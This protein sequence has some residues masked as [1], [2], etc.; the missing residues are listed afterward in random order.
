MAGQKID[1]YKEFT[2]EGDAYLLEPKALL[3]VVGHIWEDEPDADMST[4]FSELYGN[5]VKHKALSISKVH[6]PYRRYFVKERESIVVKVGLEFET[7]NIASS[8]RAL[9]KLNTLYGEGYI[10]VGVFITSDRKDTTAARIWPTRNRNGSFQ[11]LEQRQYL[12]NVRFPIWEFAFQPDGYDQRAPYLNADRS[13]YTPEDTGRTRRHRGVR[14]R[15]FTRRLKT[16]KRSWK[17][18]GRFYFL[19]NRSKGV[20]LVRWLPQARAVRRCLA[21]GTSLLG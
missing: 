20:K 2:C 3:E 8:F 19:P 10:D 15:V 21:Y 5:Y 6:E 14:Y 4:V 1:A 18:R 13:L 12:S 17:Q 9:S 7:G 16:R 11:E